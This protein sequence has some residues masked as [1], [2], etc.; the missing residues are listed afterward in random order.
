MLCLDFL[1]STIVFYRG[2]LQLI[3]PVVSFGAV[4]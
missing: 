1:D 2:V 4:D 3:V